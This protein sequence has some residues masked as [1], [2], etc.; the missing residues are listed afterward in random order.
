MP[1]LGGSIAKRNLPFF[2]LA[3]CSSSMSV[4]GKIEALNQGVRDAIPEMRR[5]AGDNPGA[6][7]VISVLKFSDGAVW[8]G[9][10]NQP[11]ETFEWEDL[12]TDGLTEMG[13]AL[14]K[15]A[16]ELHALPAGTRLLP[17]VVLLMSDGQPSDDFSSG[18]RK[19]LAEPWGKKAVKIAIAI[20]QDADHGP[21]QQFIDNREIPVLTANNS[22]QLVK[23]IKWASTVP[24][25]VA[26][27]PNIGSNPLATPPEDS[28]SSPITGVV[29]G[30]DDDLTW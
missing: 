18:L 27:N 21:L 2:I 7:V 8:H 25:K 16:D 9:A 26:S 19:L 24:I 22:D 10:K 30:D 20:G 13:R 4:D 23:R 28:G 12:T 3:D 29:T 6:N 15:V 5:V 14:E 11:V 1:E 17:P